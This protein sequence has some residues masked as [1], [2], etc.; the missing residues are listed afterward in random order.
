MAYAGLLACLGNP[1]AKYENTRHNMGF[2]LLDLLLAEA[3]RQ[4]QVRELN[5][6]RFRGQLWAFSLPPITGEWLAL[7]P[8]TYMNDSGLSVQPALAWHNLEPS[9]LVVAHDEMDIPAGALRFK[10]GG[11]LAG[12]NGLAS[13]AQHLGTKDFY[14]LR[15]GIGKPARREDVLGWVLG[16]PAPADKNK[17]CLSLPLALSTFIIFA[18]EGLARAAEFAHHAL[19]KVDA[20]LGIRKDQEI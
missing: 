17:I 12:H 2:M 1:G 3:D 14:R 4:G 15:I 19:E 20:E 18:T 11:G 6:K 5:G 13:I 10:S 16:R 9:Q 8:H 7:A